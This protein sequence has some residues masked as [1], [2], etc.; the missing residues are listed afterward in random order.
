MRA[1]I[2]GPQGLR[3]NEVPEPRPLPGEALVRVAAISL[4]R[5]EVKRALSSTADWRPGWDAAGT[6]E[7]PAADGSGPPAGARVVG[8]LPSGAWAER[9][10]VP[11]HSLAEVPAGVSLQQAATLPVAGLTALHAIYQGGSLLGRR[12]LV[13]GASGGVGLFACQL[14]RL[15]GADVAGLVRTHRD[16]V[17]AT[18]AEPIAEVTARAPY[19]LIVESVG[20]RALGAALA[21]LAPDGVCVSFGTSE[22]S[23][24]TLDV[25]GFFRVGGPRLFGLVLTHELRRESAAVGLGRLL[26]LID[27]GRL[28]TS[29][30]VAAP[31]TEVAAL[32]ADLI[33]RRFAGKAVLEVA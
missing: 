25:G 16:V 20:G 4:N 28:K 23:T 2:A 8:L 22:S 31:W 3:I 14:A 7:V 5:G 15:S 11:T 12:V 13:T 21:A 27:E 10:A 6:V 18:G 17:A 9:V 1:I 32:A 30:E 33:D 26:R 29:V 24:A 19:H